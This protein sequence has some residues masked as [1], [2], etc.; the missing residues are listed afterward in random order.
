MV[1]LGNMSD[2]LG[3]RAGENLGDYAGAAAALE[4]AVA[5]S[6]EIAA[7]IPGTTGGRRSTW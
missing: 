5:I 3:A 7:A 6:R 4:R 1:A 2:L